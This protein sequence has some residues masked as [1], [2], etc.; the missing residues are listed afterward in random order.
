[1]RTT[2]K[3][4]QQKEI[5]RERKLL[6]SRYTL[7][8][9][10]FGIL[11][12]TIL[13]LLSKWAGL[14]TAAANL[15]SVLTAALAGPLPGIITAFAANTLTG[16]TSPSALA[17]GVIPVTIAALAACFSKK[18]F[19]KSLQGS[20]F[21]V[22]CFSLTA[23]ALNLIVQCFFCEAETGL[24]TS[25][26]I[27]C[28]RDKNPGACITVLGSETLK[29]LPA[30]LLTVAAAAAALHFFTAAIKD[31]FPLSWLYDRTDAEAKLL[32]EEKMR[33]TARKSV[34]GK[35]QLL[36]W[37][38]AALAGAVAVLCS[39]VIYNNELTKLYKQTA[40]SYSK[41]VAAAIDGDLIEGWLASG[42]TD[43]EYQAVR[44]R[45]QTMNNGVSELAFVYIY[46]IAKDKSIVVMDLDRPGV[47]ADACG[48][49]LSNDAGF[50]PYLKSLL[51]GKEVSP[52]ITNDSYGWLATAYSPV[53]NSR[54][55]TVA[56]A[57]ADMDLN[58]YIQ[59]ALIYFIYILTA[60]FAVTIATAIAAVR[61]ASLRI[62]EP[63]DAIVRLNHSFE[64]TGPEK[65]LKDKDWLE[66]PE[67]T[68]GDEIEELYHT[69]CSAQQSASD[70]ISNLLK[71]EKELLRSKEIENK[72]KEL[73]EAIQKA[74][75][76]SSA[77][78]E[79]FSRMSHD[80][81]TPMNAV[82]CL[83]EF[84]LECQDTDEAK[85]LFKKI[86]SSGEYLLQLINDVLDI[87]R[88]ET[89]K[90]TLNITPA[91]ST[92]FFETIK[93]IIEPRAKAKGLSFTITGIPRRPVTYLFDKIR[94]RQIFL[95]LLNN[96][97]KFTPPGGH[98]IFSCSETKLENGEI[99]VTLQV[100]DDGIG[101]TEEFLTNGL[102]RPF[103]Q[104]RRDNSEA[105]TGLG[106]SIVKRLVEAMEGTISCV[107]ALDRGTR[108][109]VELRTRKA[110]GV[111]TEAAKAEEEWQELRGKRALICEDHPLNR[112]IA[113]KI[114][115]KVGIEADFAVNGKEGLE[116]FE[117][118]EPGRW[119]FILMDM[120]MPIMD[121]LE[122][123]R[124]IRAPKRK[125][126]ARSP[127]I[128][129]T[130]NAFEED[131]KTSLEAGMNAHLSKPVSPGK[132]Y[133]LL[134]TLL[135]ESRK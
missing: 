15:G 121:G 111:T 116:M 91:P 45:L 55:E 74:D 28:I 41:I 119:D 50:A 89:G 9:C 31:R 77:K 135:K 58:S 115:K 1:M 2:V 94:T 37:G 128:A 78:N 42:G 29:Q 120:R 85:K 36:I 52:I 24:L 109:T 26:I 5:G 98:V 54:G 90:L 23:A 32:L 126:A 34:S 82:L 46:K 30:M 130:A 114:L 60:I 106:L 68:T 64:E 43:S 56:Y 83:S 112:E 72:N 107:S 122:A 113:G 96:A 67:I 25:C 97:V 14:P 110:E 118:A 65:W 134:L 132:L 80:M 133:A 129:S 100:S 102:Y 53:R 18:G 4:E 127:I 105:G 44:S 92:E 93:S 40:L 62:T 10:C 123:T 73:A 19:F 17:H 71:A 131:I 48:T 27:E 86:Y 81:R 99:L 16:L 70:T 6:F 95:N 3:A 57:A 104:E 125:D 75:E 22:L 88:I 38:S 108:F 76:A 11:L 79:F 49:I 47:P 87:R 7:L 12:N 69:V 84:G 103:A 8:L 20:L 61:F 63:I 124:A 66:R 101:M 117:A 39:A 59:G 21:I 51:A 35:I 33:L 13:F